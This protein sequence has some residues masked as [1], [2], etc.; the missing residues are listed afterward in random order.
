M[1]QPADPSEALRI[2]QLSVQTSSISLFKD[3]LVSDFGSL[4][5]ASD[6]IEDHFHSGAFGIDGMIERVFDPLL[7]DLSLGHPLYRPLLA[8]FQ[9]FASAL[10]HKITNYKKVRSLYLWLCHESSHRRPFRVTQRKHRYVLIITIL[11]QLL[12]VVLENQW[13]GY[14][15]HRWWD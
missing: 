7:D 4:T 10:A 2:L 13:Q 5:R 1:F 11:F 9:T 15:L 6:I 14:C 3:A 12:T 8:L